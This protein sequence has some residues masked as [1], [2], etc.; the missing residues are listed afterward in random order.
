MN[1]PTELLLMRPSTVWEHAGI[2]CATILGPLGSYN[3]YCVLP[4]G[5][6][7]A[8]KDLQSEQV[9]DVHGGITFGPVIARDGR[10]VIGWDT[11]HFGDYNESFYPWGRRW[12]E[13]DVIN[14]TNRLAKQ[15]A[16]SP[17]EAA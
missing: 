6:E 12:T 14:E 17:G 13:E 5:H 8:A 7:L 1:F 9:L 15:I 11:C 16:S 3:G 10:S 2:T 4:A